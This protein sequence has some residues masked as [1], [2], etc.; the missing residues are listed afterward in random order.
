MHAATNFLDRGGFSSIGLRVRFSRKHKLDMLLFPVS[1]EGTIYRYTLMLTSYVSLK[2][3][4]GTT[5][6]SMID[7]ND[8]SSLERP[9][10]NNTVWILDNEGKV[11]TADSKEK[12]LQFKKGLTCN[13]I[14]L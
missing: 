11:L 8:G 9:T 5:A 12:G 3:S 2:D 13:V 7:G 1:Y 14:V 6:S 4:N 10:G